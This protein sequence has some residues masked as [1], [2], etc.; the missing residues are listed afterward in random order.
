MTI[1]SAHLISFAMMLLIVF[2][3]LISLSSATDTPPSQEIPEGCDIVP[4]TECQVT[5][6]GGWQLGR[7]VCIEKTEKCHC[8][9][10]PVFNQCNNRPCLGKNP[11]LLDVFY[12]E[13]NKQQ[14]ENGVEYVEESA[15]VVPIKKTV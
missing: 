9:P 12:D 13:E 10:N 7:Y 11:T 1:G 15:E 5:C 6:G 4:V 14:E 8:P 2:S 3:L